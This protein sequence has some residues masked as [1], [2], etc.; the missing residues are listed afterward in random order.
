MQH[1]ERVSDLR[2]PLLP[3][4]RG[5]FLGRLVQQDPEAVVLVGD[6]GHEHANHAHMG[7]HDP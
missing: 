6:V 1:G 2:C 5:C 3:E 7:L 4:G